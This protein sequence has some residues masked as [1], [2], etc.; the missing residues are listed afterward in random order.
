MLSK[1]ATANFETL[2]RAA[3]DDNLA[4]MECTDAKTGEK[5][6]VICAVQTSVAEDGVT[7]NYAF[8]PLAKQFMNSNPYEEVL[9]PTNETEV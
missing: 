5:V 6:N 9:P 1:A 2:K 3:E 8:V 7:L 4:L